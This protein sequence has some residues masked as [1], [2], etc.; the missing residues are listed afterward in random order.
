MCSIMVVTRPLAL[1]DLYWCP[2]SFY[3][4][5]FA[6]MV[7]CNYSVLRCNIL[8][9]YYYPARCQSAICLI[10]LLLSFHYLPVFK[11]AFFVRLK[12]NLS[13][14]SCHNVFS[15]YFTIS[16]VSNFYQYFFTIVSLFPRVFMTLNKCS[17]RLLLFS[18]LLAI[19]EHEHNT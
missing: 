19:P 18:S 6:G 3:S 5:D 4:V 13:L 8:N 14:P 17:D 9:F 12:V 15:H 16:L 11:M 10:W 7:L 2:L 1:T